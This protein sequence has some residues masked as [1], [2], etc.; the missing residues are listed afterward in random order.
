VLKLKVTQIGNSEGVIL[1]KEALSRLNIAK[2]DAVFLTET[3]DGYAI[4]AYDPHFE[5]VMEVAEELARRYKNALRELA[6]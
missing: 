5:K 1:P 6:K 4:T 3:P 2:G